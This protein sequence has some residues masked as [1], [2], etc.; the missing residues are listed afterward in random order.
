MQSWD[1]GTKDLW[2]VDWG[3]ARA[4]FLSM[5]EDPRSGRATVIRHSL[6][7][8]LRSGDNWSPV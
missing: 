7:P 5:S 2:L 4:L 3:P 8:H 6:S 1:R